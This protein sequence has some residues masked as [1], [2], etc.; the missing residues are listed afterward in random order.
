M[1]QSVNAKRRSSKFCTH[2]TN[3]TYTVCRESTLQIQHIHEQKKILFFSFHIKHT[4]IRHIKRRIYGGFLQP[5]RANV[6]LSIIC[7][8]LSHYACTLQH[9]HTKNPTINNMP[10]NDEYIFVIVFKYSKLTFMFSLFFFFWL[11]FSFSLSLSASLVNREN[12][13]FHHNFA[14]QVVFPSI[15]MMYP[16]TNSSYSYITLIVCTRHII[17]LYKYSF[18]RHFQRSFGGTR[19]KN[20]FQKIIKFY[21]GH[22]RII[23]T[24]N[25]YGDGRFDL[26]AH[27]LHIP[28]LNFGQKCK[29]NAQSIRVY[30][31]NF[32]NSTNEK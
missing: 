23:Y 24:S 16:N 22:F 13:F 21:I 18:A 10:N 29:K 3:H 1:I 8:C 4:K 31:H 20:F 26:Y 25:T 14:E 30:V 28:T 32:G 17:C 11:L 15:M 12:P 27:I 2:F 6:C 5:Q 7:T 9:T 19:N